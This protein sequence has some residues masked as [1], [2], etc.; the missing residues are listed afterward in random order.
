M[1]TL[2][3]AALLAALSVLTGCLNGAVYTNG[4]IAR[5]YG[6]EEV[7]YADLQTLR[8]LGV[9]PQRFVTIYGVRK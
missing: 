3:A 1:P 9:W 4:T 7:Y 8:V 6:F 5:D 2:R